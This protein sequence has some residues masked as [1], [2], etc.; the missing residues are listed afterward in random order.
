MLDYNG[1][2]L[3]ERFLCYYGDIV[4]NDVCVFGYWDIILNS[5]WVLE[6]LMFY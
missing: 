2:F 4:D 6:I 1:I 5:V 3:V